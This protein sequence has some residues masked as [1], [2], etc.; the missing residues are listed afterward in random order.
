MGLGT[1]HISVFAPPTLSSALQRL[2]PIM[3]RIVPASEQ[4][5]TR[6]Q[7][8]AETELVAN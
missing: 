5:I 1:L 4:R 3:V 2:S 6:L 7:Q 8:S